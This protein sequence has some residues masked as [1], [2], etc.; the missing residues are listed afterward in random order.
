M[1]ERKPRK[2]RTR[3]T[4]FINGLRP[5][6]ATHFRNRL[7]RSASR[8]LPASHRCSFL[9]ASFLNRSSS[10]TCSPCLLAAS[11]AL[12][13]AEAP[14]PIGAQSLHPWMRPSW[15]PPDWPSYSLVQLGVSHHDPGSVPDGS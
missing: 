8:A 11:D 15:V 4:G 1:L 3:P 5:I 10:S 7:L 12:W 9:G 13:P 2:M 6:L 14:A